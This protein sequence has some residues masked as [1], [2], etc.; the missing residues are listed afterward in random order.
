M[1][2]A[3]VRLGIGRFAFFLR[4][5]KRTVIHT[6]NDKRCVGRVRV[7]Y[8][9]VVK[10]YGSWRVSDRA[11]SRRLP[12]CSCRGTYRATCQA[13][14]QDSFQGVCRPSAGQGCSATSKRRT[15][16]TVHDERENG[17][18]DL[19]FCRGGSG[20]TV[21]TQTPA[22]TP[23]SP[24]ISLSV[25]AYAICRDKFDALVERE[26]CVPA[27]RRRSGGS[28]RKMMSK[29]NQARTWTCGQ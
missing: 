9:A 21:P 1:Q 23:L 26:A 24:S 17:R 14:R 28:G 6:P 3:L 4:V 15:Q 11:A 8:S 18:S 10:G 5:D 29:R 22:S 20:E 19:T 25:E 2:I 16:S 13:R 12:G 27:S 7:R